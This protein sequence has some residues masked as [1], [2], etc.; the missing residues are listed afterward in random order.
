L[1]LQ[2]TCSNTFKLA[3]FSC[4]MSY[5]VTRVKYHTLVLIGIILY[6][7]TRTCNMYRNV[8]YWFFRRHVPVLLN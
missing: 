4:T 8:N 5:T 7:I 2:K 3:L 6:E 1:V